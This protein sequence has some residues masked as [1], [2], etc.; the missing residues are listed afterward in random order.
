MVEAIPAI[1]TPKAIKIFEEHGVLTAGECHS[2][3]EISYEDYTKKIDIEARTMIDMGLKQIKPAVIKYTKE[4]ADAVASLKAVGADASVEEELLKE[5]TTELNNLSNCIIKLKEA[6]ASASAV[7]DIEAQ[8][9]AY[10]DNVFTAMAQLR[11][12]ADKLEMMVDET[13]WPF[14][15]YGQLLFNI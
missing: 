8:A 13:I 10:K 6:L 12:P 14:P 1:V 15:T 7:E 4:I 11:E 5:L 2:R 3:A 9:V